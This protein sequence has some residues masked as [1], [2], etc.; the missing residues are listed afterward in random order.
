VRRSHPF[1]RWG[2]VPA[3]LGLVRLFTHQFLHADVLHLVF[4]MVFLWAVGALLEWSLGSAGFVAAYLATG[5][6]AGLLHAAANTGSTQPAIGASGAVAGLMGLFAVRHGR[7]RLRFVLVAA[8]F[9]PRIHVLSWPAWVFLG[10]WLLEQLFYASFGKTGLGVAFLAHLG[11]FA[12]G[13][14]LGAVLEMAGVA[15]RPDTP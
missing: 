15:P 3:D 4:N 11:G 7:T 5:I 14:A 10:L 2:L 12:A 9:S 8:S 13:A 6:A 1:Y